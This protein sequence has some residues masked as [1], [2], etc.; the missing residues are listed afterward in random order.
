VD[1]TKSNKTMSTKLNK[2][3]YLSHQDS[4][5][6]FKWLMP[7]FSKENLMS[8]FNELDGKKAVGIDGLTK[9]GY[10]QDAINNIV[11]LVKRMKNFS[12][13]P[14]PVREVQIPKGDGKF[15]PL[16]ISAIEDKIIQS[17]YCKILEAIYE[18]IFCDCSY[19]FRRNKSA[20]QGIKD[21]ID[22]LRFNNVKKVIDVDLE[23]FF[24]TIRH[25]DLLEMLSLKIKDKT[26][27]RYIAR[28]L[29]AGKSTDKG[30]V[31]SDIG[32]PQGSILSPVLANVYA[33]YIID[34]WFQK[35]VPKHIIGKVAI[36]RYCD[37][38]IVCCTDT[39]DVTRV[40]KSF[41]KRLDRF[42]MKLNTSK[43]KVVKFNRYDFQR[44]IKQENFDFLGFSFY[45][46]KAI[47]DGFITVKIKTSKKALRAKLKNVKTWINRNRFK[48]GLLVLWKEFCRKLQGHIAYFGVTNNSKSVNIFLYEARRVFFKWMN[49][50]SQKRSFNWE[51]FSNFEK[52]YP[53]PR[54]KIYHQV[55]KSI[56]NS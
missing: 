4:K 38:L 17:M 9:E 12:Y 40:M 5:M 46:S 7:H 28:M 52:Q 26:F 20:H 14:K 47:K 10:A 54:T 3:S 25:D 24:G 33:H 6:E 49:R 50:R 44:G 51:Q 32:L 30:I 13:R 45:L 37:D 41:E 27:L 15:R 23:N 53:M 16:G 21:A 56:S 18:P 22:Y 39:R 36:F 48:G 19:G 55:Y 2:I 31:K 34:L 43:T 42:G 1:I 11:T 8:C 29:K 35:V